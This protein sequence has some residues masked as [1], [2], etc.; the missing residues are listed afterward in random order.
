M[1]RTFST[2]S[3]SGDSLNFSLRCGCKPNARQMRA[4]VE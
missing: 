2:S 4:T 1:S 3:G